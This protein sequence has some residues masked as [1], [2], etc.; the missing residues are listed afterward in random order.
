[1]IFKFHSIINKFMY[2]FQFHLTHTFFHIPML[3][4]FEGK[5]NRTEIKEMAYWNN[6][7]IHEY[8]KNGTKVEFEI[9]LLFLAVLHGGVYGLVNCFSFNVQIFGRNCNELYKWNRKKN[10]C[11]IQIKR[12]LWLFICVMEVKLFFLFKWKLQSKNGWW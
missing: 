7:A 3:H 12:K 6:N 10:C 11:I 2:E 9:V 5:N 1:M 4:I 8:W